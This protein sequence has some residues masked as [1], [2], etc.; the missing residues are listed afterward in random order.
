MSKDSKDISF[1]DD[2]RKSLLSGVEKLAR[3]VKTTLGPRGRNVVIESR[4]A[5]PHITKDGVTV[6]KSVKLGNHLENIGAQ[7][8]KE[9]ALK[10][11]DIAGDGPQPLYAKVL[12]P[13]GFKEMGDIREGDVV[14]GTDGSTQS[15]LGVY[16]KGKREICEVILSDGR[17]VECCEDHLFTVVTNYGKK[18]TLT[19]KEMIESGRIKVA[20]KDG[21]DKYGYYIPTSIPDF[22]ERKHILDPYL[23]G[24]LIGDGYFPKGARDRVELSIGY[25]KLHVLENIK[26]PTGISFSKNDCPERNYMKVRFQGCDASGRTLKALLDEIGLGGKGSHDKFIPADYLYSDINSREELLQGLIDTDGH[27]N[28]RGRFEFST[29]SS[30]LF[31]DFVELCTGLGIPT[32]TYS[33][34]NRAGG[35][36][37]TT[38]LRVSQLK[39]YKHGA[40][41]VDIIRTGRHTEMQCIKVSNDDHLYFTD[42]YVL[43]HNTTT[44]TVLAEAILKEGMRLVAAGNDPMSLKRGID[45]AVEVVVES[46][47]SQSREV[48]STHEIR[49]VA[50]ISANGDEEIGNMIAEAMDA[51]GKDGV[52]TLEEGKGFE[53]ELRV[54]NGF[55]FDRGYLSPHFC[56]DIPRQRVVYDNALVW[57]VNGKLSGKN[58]LEQMLPVLEWCS[59]EGKPIVLIAETIEGEILQTLLI[60]NLKGALQCVAIKAPGFGDR[61]TEML[62]DLAAL[63]GATLRDPTTMGTSSLVKNMTQEELGVCARIEV[64]RDSTVIIAADGV[65]ES[66]E[67]RVATIRAQLDQETDTWDRERTKQRLGKLTGGVGVI[68]VG[69]A[70]EI[71]VKEKKDRLE[72]AL[73]ATKAAVE[74]GIVP[75]GGVALVRAAQKLR[76]FSTGNSEEDMGVKIVLDAIQ[77]PLMHIAKNAGEHGDVIVRDVQAQDNLAV[78]FNAAKREFTDMFEAG[79]VDPAKVTRVATQNAASI[80]GLMLTTECVV[81]FDSDEEQNQHPGANMMM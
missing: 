68:L 53:S 13:N 44:A 38:V 21:S 73:S 17:I 46:V 48:S 18:K 12:T 47:K 14:C 7:M 11:A 24:L 36:S 9:V 30:R 42:N 80:A 34:E 22:P 78:G 52:I 58:T 57:L 33:V 31:Q 20:Q 63:T 8:V 65:E 3:A 55:E 59:N 15:V 51:V 25:S 41:I 29:V 49:Q 4:T 23:I 77:M 62:G 40:K 69:G 10:T 50:T 60:N 16:P 81:A 74:E 5:P 43:T 6:A 70:T 66:V 39:G 1:E 26:L 64:S 76:D 19:V 61:R 67:S 32:H 27:I 54:S 45:K 37:D 71:E 79:I 2:A 35:Y 75:G 28:T 56:N 72:D